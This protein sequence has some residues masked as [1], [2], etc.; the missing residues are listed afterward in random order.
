ML[1]WG[2]LY[3]DYVIPLGGLIIVVCL[4][5]AAYTLE[6]QVTKYEKANKELYK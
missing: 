1:F 6:V 4:L 2:M 3:D 5:A